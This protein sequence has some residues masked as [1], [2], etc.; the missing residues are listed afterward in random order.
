MEQE[1]Q[2]LDYEPLEESVARLSEGRVYYEV[3]PK[4]GGP[5]EMEANAALYWDKERHRWLAEVSGKFLEG[6]EGGYQLILDFSH[7][8]QTLNQSACRKVLEAYGIDQSKA[9]LSDVPELDPSSLESL[10]GMRK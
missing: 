5:Y 8:P 9:N 6:Y 10:V 4:W 3:K 7:L 2:V 1:M